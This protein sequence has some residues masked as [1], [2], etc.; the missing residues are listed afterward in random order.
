MHDISLYTRSILH[1][2]INYLPNIYNDYVVTK[3]ECSLE[4]EATDGCSFHYLTEFH[5]E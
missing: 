2:L 1:N 5:Y 3:E 4:K